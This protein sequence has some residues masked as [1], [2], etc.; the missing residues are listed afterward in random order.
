VTRVARPS[1]SAALVR[2]DGTIAPEWYRYFTQLDQQSGLS[3][4]QVLGNL[5]EDSLTL[6]SGANNNIALPGSAN[7]IEITGPTGAFSTTGFVAPSTS[8]LVLLYTL[9]TAG[10]WTIAHENSG[11]TAA[12]RIKAFTAAN[13]TVAAFGGAV[14]LAYSI[15]QTRWLALSIE[16]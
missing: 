1:P 10:A 6:A 12:N 5:Q 13:V 14:L 7:F 9:V 8:Q 4:D 2:T 16:T 3:A 15:R 11:S